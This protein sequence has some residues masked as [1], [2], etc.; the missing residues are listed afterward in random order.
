MELF[1]KLTTLCLS[2][3]AC[4]KWWFDTS[5]TDHIIAFLTLGKIS[6]FPEFKDK[7]NRGPISRLLVELWECPW[8]LAF[9]FSLWLNG[10]ALFYYQ[11]DVFQF[12][13]HVIACAG[14]SMFLY[15][16]DIKE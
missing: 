8:C 4:L 13:I 3:Y 5:L 10:F 6:T 16:V 12:A 15:Q 2:V 11:F 1:I 14:G 9:H 7:V